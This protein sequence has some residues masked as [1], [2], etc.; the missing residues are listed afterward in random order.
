MHVLNNAV[1]SLE[2]VGGGEVVVSTRTEGEQVIIEITDNGTGIAEPSRVFD[3]FYT[4]KPLGQGTGL[5]LSA[6]YGIIQEHQGKIECFN[7]EPRGATFRITLKAVRQPA[8][9]TVTAS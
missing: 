1:D 3:P 4:T 2:E 9:E 6:C 7:L 5:G 8:R